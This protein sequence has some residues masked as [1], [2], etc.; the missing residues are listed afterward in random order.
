MFRKE[1]VQRVENSSAFSEARKYGFTELQSRII[2]GRATRANGELKSVLFPTLNNLHHPNSLEDGAT[3]AA[4]IVEAILEKKRIGILTDYDVDGICSHVVVHESLRHFGVKTDLL[5]SFIG[6]RMNDGYGISQNL[7]DRILTQ[8][9]QPNLIITADCG[10][11]D[12]KQIKRLKEAGMTVIVTDHHAIP[13]EGIPVSAAA[14]VNPSREDCRYP[15]KLIS[16]CMVSWLVMCLVRNVLREK[17]YLF[18]TA[19]QLASLLDY[20]ALSTVADAVSFFSGT[21][22]AVVVSGLRIINRK[23][24]P[25]WFSLASLL[26][27]TDDSP[28]TAEDLAFQVAPRINARGRMADPYAALNFFLAESTEQAEAQLLKL[29]KNNEQRKSAEREMVRTARKEAMCQIRSGRRSIVVADAAFHPGVQGIVASRLVDDCGRPAVVLSPTKES[30][31]LSG[32]VRSVPEVD[33]R[34]VLQKIHE[35]RPELFLSFGGH[36]GAA[37]LKIRLEKLAEFSAAFEKVVCDETAG[38]VLRPIITTDGPLPTRDMTFETIAELHALEPF[39]R[40]FDEPV[41]EGMFTVKRIRPVGAES[42]HLAMTLEANNGRTFHGIWFRA[43][44][45]AEEEV[46]IKGGELIRCAFKLKINTFR[47]NTNIQMMIEYAEASQRL[48][49]DQRNRAVQ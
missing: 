15:D 25:S 33:V 38:R 30:D 17:K 2:A 44:E 24:K 39:G 43:L 6:H 20:V 9:Q 3:A 23:T 45:N 47:G 49:G 29:E 7:A 21:N 32:S 4:V 1:I 41:F 13:A 28:F 31:I 8:H 34:N 19:N 22:R 5:S 12:E 40:E 18:E 48:Q 37:G 11:S 16:G 10:S 14:T 36:S 46:S 27:K 42:I 35:K 26:G